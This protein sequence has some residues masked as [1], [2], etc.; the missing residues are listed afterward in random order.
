NSLLRWNV[1]YWWPPGNPVGHGNVLVHNCLWA[2]NP[3]E[4]GMYSRR[5]GVDVPVGFT[6]QRN[7]VAK[8]RFADAAAGDFAQRRGSG[9]AG[10]G[11]RYAFRED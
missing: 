5:G 9:C 8:P 7:R 4:G 2:S 1:E 10:Y 3:A 11:P 6:A